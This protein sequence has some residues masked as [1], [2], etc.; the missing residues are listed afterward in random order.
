[1]TR[2]VLR[3]IL[4]MALVCGLL[5]A[6]RADAVT[7][8]KA[9]GALVGMAIA[10]G[11]TPSERYMRG[12]GHELASQATSEAERV[13]ATAAMEDFGQRAMIQQSLEPTMSCEAVLRMFRQS[14]DKY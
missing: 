4:S 11:E 13:E 1:M 5:S 9:A 7:F 8:G 3:M 6:A 2:Y 14:N 12:I 10:C